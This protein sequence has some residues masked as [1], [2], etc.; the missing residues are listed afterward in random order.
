LINV[1]AIALVVAAGIGSSSNF[2]LEIYMK[3]FGS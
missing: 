3:A 2:N 1:A